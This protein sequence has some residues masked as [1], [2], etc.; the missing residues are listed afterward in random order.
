MSLARHFAK[1]RFAAELIAVE[2]FDSS[3]IPKQTG[4]RISKAS[5]PSAFKIRLPTDWLYSSLPALPREGIEAN[6]GSQR[7]QVSA[8][9]PGYLR[10]Q[11][12]PYLGEQNLTSERAARHC[13]IAL[14]EIDTHLSAQGTTLARL[15]DDMKK[16]LALRLILDTELPIASLGARVGYPDPTSFSR[17]FRRW[18]GTS[19]RKYRSALQE[20][21]NAAAI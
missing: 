10:C 7:L 13:S 16:E 18:T 19:P 2:L 9:L 14:Q 17:A 4:I 5:R 6:E 12:A 3:M 21:T 15:I 11:L 8:L 1:E 20:E